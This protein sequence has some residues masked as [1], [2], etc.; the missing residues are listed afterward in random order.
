MDAPDRSRLA[1]RLVLVFAVLACL[2]G[3]GNAVAAA[4]GQAE[5]NAASTVEVVAPA[6]HSLA[7]SSAHAASAGT[8]DQPAGTPVQQNNGHGGHGSGHDHAV[9]CM[10]SSA[11]AALG[12]V[13]VADAAALVI[14]AVPSLIR[15]HEA[16]LPAAE[17]R[18]P[19]ITTLCVQRT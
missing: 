7:H 4:A 12:A 8:L 1:P 16:A 10:V 9:T 5:Q 13:S 19:S 3:W 14:S 2:F 11:A 18:A 15:V 6:A 17:Q